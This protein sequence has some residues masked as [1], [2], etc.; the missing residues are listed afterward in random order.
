MRCQSEQ[1]RHCPTPADQGFEEVNG[2]SAV[3]NSDVPSWVVTEAQAAATRQRGQAVD[4]NNRF[5]IPVEGVS[6]TNPFTAGQQTGVHF[7]TFVFF[8]LFLRM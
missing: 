7:L 3:P 2:T 5:T 8:V 1:H 4:V 6:N